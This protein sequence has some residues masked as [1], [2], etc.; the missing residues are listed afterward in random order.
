[1]K[2]IFVRGNIMLLSEGTA[3]IVLADTSENPKYRG[4]LD[5]T[6]LHVLNVKR[7]CFHKNFLFISFRKKNVFI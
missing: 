5:T 3:D 7:S 2:S 6:L 4:G 1:M